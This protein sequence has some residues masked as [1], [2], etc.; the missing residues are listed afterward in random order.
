[1][2]FNDIW[3]SVTYVRNEDEEIIAVEVPIEQW[4]AL[5][6]RVQAMQDREA[7]RQRLARLRPTQ[8]PE[9]SDQS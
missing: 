8:D 7:A 1:M 2:D 3:E 9:K 6:D 4:R 5:L